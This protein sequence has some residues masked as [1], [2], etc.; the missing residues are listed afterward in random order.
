MQ[1]SEMI[2]LTLIFILIVV[3]VVKYILHMRHMESYVKHLN[4]R[5][6]VYPLLG[7]AHFTFR[8]TTTEVFK[9][10]MEFTKENDTPYKSYIGPALL[11]VI[12]IDQI[13]YG[14]N[15]KKFNFYQQTLDKPE[16]L[17]T[18]LTSPLCLSKPFVY[19]FYPSPAGILTVR[20]KRP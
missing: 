13:N 12:K 17:K 18:V 8:K 15:V 1:E 16:D 9:E 14:L 3:I 4:I 2:V 5:R 6:P 20:C 11:I 19:Q 10:I 7:N